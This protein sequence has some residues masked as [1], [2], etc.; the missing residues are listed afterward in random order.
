M[1]RRMQETTPDAEVV[2][3]LAEGKQ[4]AGQILVVTDELVTVRPKPPVGVAL[5]P[6]RTVRV[7]AVR[8]VRTST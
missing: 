1:L 2:L 7:A 4:V 3:L 8:E 6:A 5:E